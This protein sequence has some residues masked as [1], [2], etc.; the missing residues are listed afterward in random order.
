M[1]FLEIVLNIPLNQSFTYTDCVEKSELT[2]AKKN[3]R[4][5]NYT[6]AV[7]KR[8]EV[9]FGSRKLIGIIIAIHDKKPKN[10]PVDE[11]K[12]KPILRVLDKDALLTKELISLGFWLSDFYLCTIGESLCSMIPS[13]KKEKDV[14]SLSIIEDDVF[15]NAHQMSTEQQNA[16]N[17][18]KLLSEDDFDSKH[19][20][21]YLYGPTG[22]GK[23]EVFLSV[24]QKALNAG[25]GVIYLVPEIALTSQVTKALTLRFGKTVA[26]LHSALTPSQKLSEW[27]RLLCGDAKIALGARSAIFAPVKNLGLI[28]IDE[29][30]D[31]SYKSGNTPRYH[32]RQVAMH[33]AKVLKIPLVMGSA[34][35]SV[36]SWNAIKTGAFV[37]HTLTK[38][39]AGGTMPTIKCINLSSSNISAPSLPSVNSDGGSISRELEEEIRNT[40]E[41][42]RQAI[43]FLNRRGFNHFFRCAS[44]GFE[45]KCINCSVPLTYHKAENK[46]KCHYC[47]YFT[48]PPS[49]CPACGS[50]DIGY[51]GFGT[52]FIES[53]AKAKFPNA[54]IIRVDTDSLTKKGELED[55]ID[56]FKKA[57]YDIM[58]GT[59]MIAKGL[60]FPRLKTVGVILADTGLHL[61]DFRSSERTF[62]L[63]TQVAGRAGRFFPDGKV[64]VQTYDVNNPAIFFACHSLT[65]E[66]YEQELNQRKVLCFPP[67]SR[68]VRLVFRGL[69]E[70][71]VEQSAE[72]AKKIL[73]STLEELKTHHIDGIN[74]TEI[75]GPG[76]CPLLKISL[77]FRYQ[78]IL[79]S[80]SIAILQKLCAH[81]IYDFK[82]P[83]GIYIEVDVDPVNM[84]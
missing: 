81:L 49:S 6:I 31:S 63:I 76:E 66:F 28:I 68:L 23:T 26:I 37:S 22:S 19:N 1:K 10:C 36:E 62:S 45:L 80:A 8:A 50:M 14:G 84:L 60:N 21:H 7:G 13:G 73:C 3:T 78:I 40:L 18:I 74:S 77:N 79:R 67:F 32:A 65:K 44:C 57:E 69:E 29:E 59:Q 39:L 34:T 46:L 24:A 43:L 72:E 16:T 64:F 53:E 35:P 61:P 70:S 51:S 54:K 83:E 5:I 4:K 58:L 41:Q 33:R 9:F 52:E 42:K 20:F 15:E 75:L 17:D 12:I 27:N 47:G 55:A 71:N 11:S 25:F 2:Q 56:S 48:T 30:H 38:R 82:K